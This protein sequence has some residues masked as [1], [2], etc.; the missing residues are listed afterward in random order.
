MN[1]K[2]DLKV[3]RDKREEQRRQFERRT[4]RVDE[5][6]R[7]VRAIERILKDAKEMLEIAEYDA[8][9]TSHTIQ[10]LNGRMS[11][12]QHLGEEKAKEVPSE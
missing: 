11:I 9:N 8:S 6:T 7:H 5:L 4:L 2:L 10:W 3:E 1:I 12:L